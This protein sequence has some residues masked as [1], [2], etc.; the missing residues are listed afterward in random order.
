MRENS[1]YEDKLDK[2][3]AESTL[4]G[5]GYFI[6]WVALLAALFTASANGWF[7]WWSMLIVFILP[8]FAG[9]YLVKVNRRQ[10]IKQGTKY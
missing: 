1:E 8:I 2:T 10:A 3:N 6:A 9:N 4:F 7:E 5:L